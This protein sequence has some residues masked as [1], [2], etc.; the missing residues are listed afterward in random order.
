M[1]V[2]I[3]NTETDLASKTM[4]NT[5]SLNAIVTTGLIL[6]KIALPVLPNIL[7][8]TGELPKSSGKAGLTRLSLHR[9]E[10]RVAVAMQRDGKEEMCESID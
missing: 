2:Q 6:D 10:E 4:F 7:G 8:G 1:L 9:R 3:L 5:P